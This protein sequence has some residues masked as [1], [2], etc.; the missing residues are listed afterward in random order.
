M[1][2]FTSATIS[3][4]FSSFVATSFMTLWSIMRPPE[5]E[6]HLLCALS[7]PVEW[8][9]TLTDWY[10][11]SGCEVMFYSICKDKSVA[12]SL[13]AD[14][15]AHHPPAPAPPPLRAPS[16]C[17]DLPSAENWLNAV[18]HWFFFS[19][20]CDSRVM[21]MV[22]EGVRVFVF[23]S[24]AAR[25]EARNPRTFTRQPITLRLLLLLSRPLFSPS[26]LPLPL[27][28]PSPTPLTN[29]INR[30]WNNQCWWSIL[31]PVDML[32]SKPHR[33]CCRV[34]N[35]CLLPECIAAG[36]ANPGPGIKHCLLT[37]NVQTF[38]CP[39]PWLFSDA[40]KVGRIVNQ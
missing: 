27:A 32:M 9:V 1:A 5:W 12:P 24:L 39:A 26:S 17:M 23:F 4:P 19:S 34:I 18:N 7:L 10:C 8:R 38:C 16:F 40:K 35:H 22:I 33:Y 31:E 6:W 20:G 25:I 15:A 29:G 37:I 13:A 36:A 21:A 28:P 2:L 11:N 30:P 14:T 3:R